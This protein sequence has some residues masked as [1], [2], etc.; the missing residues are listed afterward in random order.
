M[1]NRGQ[2]I[3]NAPTPSPILRMLL[4]KAEPMS[5][6]NTLFLLP[7]LFPPIEHP[8]AAETRPPLLITKLF[9]LPDQPT[10]IR[11]G[12]LHAEPGPLTVTLLSALWA[13]YPTYADW[14]HIA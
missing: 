5:V 12:H 9:P 8:P 6:T 1:P 14:A 2:R 7:P 3:A 11:N 4:L 10:A 13:L